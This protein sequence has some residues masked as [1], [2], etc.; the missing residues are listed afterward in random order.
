MKIKYFRIQGVQIRAQDLICVSYDM[1]FL[2]NRCK[3]RK[4]LN[5]KSLIAMIRKVCPIFS[6]MKNMT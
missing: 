3:Q 6:K 1:T 5:G 4:Y 2:H